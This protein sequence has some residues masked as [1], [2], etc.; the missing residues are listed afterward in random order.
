MT[1]TTLELIII[2]IVIAIVLAVSIALVFYVDTHTTTQGQVPSGPGMADEAGI[3][4]RRQQESA[5]G[6]SGQADEFTP[7]RPDVE[8]STER[9]AGIARDKASAG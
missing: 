9:A 1:G 8:T 3:T 7:V 6:A 4:G 2:A 5:D